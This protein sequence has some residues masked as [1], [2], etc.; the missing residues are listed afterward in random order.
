MSYIK[1]GLNKEVL[2]KHQNRPFIETNYNKIT[3]RK[4]TCG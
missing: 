1:Q 4:D 3:D 2:Y